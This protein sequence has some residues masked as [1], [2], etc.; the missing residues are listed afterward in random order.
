MFWGQVIIWWF[1]IH[2]TDHQDHVIFTAVGYHDIHNAE[3]DEHLPKLMSLLQGLYCV[4]VSSLLYRRDWQLDTFK[5]FFKHL[6]LLW[7]LGHN[8][9]SCNSYWW[10]ILV[11]KSPIYF[12]N[13]MCIYVLT[14]K[15][16]VAF[17]IIVVALKFYSC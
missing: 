10:W 9:V 1:C 7:L 2:L 5:Y 15:L 11:H 14:F 17:I 8:F 4:T 3:W 12:W 13:R 6:W 16:V